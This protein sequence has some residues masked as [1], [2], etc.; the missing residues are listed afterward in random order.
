ML[1]PLENS[2]LFCLSVLLKKLSLFKWLVAG[3]AIDS[4]NESPDHD[5]RKSVTLVIDASFVVLV[6][7]T[8]FCNTK[9]SYCHCKGEVKVLDAV[10]VVTNLFDKVCCVWLKNL[11]FF[12]P[13]I[14]RNMR[15]N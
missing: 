15:V 12:V 4:S 1:D 2:K 10:W 5:L 6:K 13:E 11:I 8:R 3:I 9:R 7:Q 14:C